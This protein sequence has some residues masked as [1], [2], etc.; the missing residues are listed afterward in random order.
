MNQPLTTHA[1]LIL[2]LR[3]GQ[4]EPAWS[5]FVD[6]YGPLIYGFARRQGLQDADA[7]DLTQEVLRA[8]ASSVGRFEYDPNK[9]KFR[10][11]LFTIV[12]NEIRDQFRQGP[13]RGNG[14]T[15]AQQFLE[16]QPGPEGNDA[17]VWDEEYR[18]RVFAWAAEQV[19]RDFREPT[20]QAFWR[21]AVEGKRGQAV[22]QEL[23][24]T[25]AAVYLA[26]SRVLA[27][28]KEQIAM[29]PEEEDVFE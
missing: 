18:R 6:L 22:A 13:D 27:R 19:R 12:R 16:Q 4:N 20:W 3:D 14:G 21:T 26:R 9:G 29:L 28:L 23:G 24:M 10:G 1:S 8:V 17:A 5:Q 2:R 15:T 7:A 25:V 11:W